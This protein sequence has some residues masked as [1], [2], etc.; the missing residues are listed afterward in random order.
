MLQTPRK[1]SEDEIKNIYN[2]GDQMTQFYKKVE[3]EEERIMQAREQI[4][5]NLKEQINKFTNSIEE[6]IKQIDGLKEYGTRFMANKMN[7]TISQLN[8]ELNDKLSERDEINQN[9][10]LLGG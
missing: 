6:F 4:E 2:T 10:E 3:Q 5:A 1:T 9:E 8:K 7:E